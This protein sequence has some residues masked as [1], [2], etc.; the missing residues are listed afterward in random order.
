MSLRTLWWSSTLVAGLVLA[1]AG[2]A[3]SAGFG[4]PDPALGFAPLLFV[5]GLM[6][7]LATP[8]VYELAGDRRGR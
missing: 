5:L 3:L 7:A 1:A 8:V 2:L 6:L 4:Q